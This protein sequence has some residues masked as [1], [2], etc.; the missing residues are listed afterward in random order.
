MTRCEARFVVA[1]RGNMRTDS[2]NFWSVRVF[3]LYATF[4]GTISYDM[5]VYTRSFNSAQVVDLSI[6]SV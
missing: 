4:S 2:K 1:S 3:L 6:R 5:V